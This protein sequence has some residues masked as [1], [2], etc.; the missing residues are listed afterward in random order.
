MTEL[1][2]KSIGRGGLRKVQRPTEKVENGGTSSH[3]DDD[4]AFS[5]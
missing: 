1:K 5:T 4:K 3:A 2:P